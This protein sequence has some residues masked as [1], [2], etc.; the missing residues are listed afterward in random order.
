MRKIFQ[1]IIFLFSIFIISV[2]SCY[3][4]AVGPSLKLNQI[5]IESDIIFKAKIISSKKIKNK[6]FEKYIGFT[7]LETKMQIISV[8]NGKILG[9]TVIFQHYGDD[10]DT[11]NYQM[12]S[13]QYYN[14]KKG[15]EYIVFAKNTDKKGIFRQLWKNHKSKMDQGVFLSADN[16]P[17]KKDSTIKQIIWDELIKLLLSSD[18]KYIVYS[19]KQLDLMSTYATW[20]K[21]DDFNR[22]DVMQKIHKFVLNENKELAKTAIRAM[23]RG[24]PYL[25]D[26]FADGWLATIGEGKIHGY[27]KWPKERE[28][29]D[30]KKYWE[31]LVSVV[32]GNGPVENRALA[33]RALGLLNES[34]VYKHLIQWVNDAEPLIRQAAII[35]LSDFPGKKTIQLIEKH[36]RDNDPKTR[37][38]VARAIGFGRYEE[39]TPV[40]E[41]LLKDKDRY[42]ANAAYISL[43]SFSLNKVEHIFKTYKNDPDWKG[44]FVNALAEQNAEPYLKDLA[45]I[46]EKRISSKYFLGGRVPTYLSWKI[47]FKHLQIQ[48]AEKLKTSEFHRYFDALDNGKYHGSSEPRDL[49]A[50]YIHLG[51]IKRAKM[52]RK[53]CKER[54]RSNMEYF[55]KMVDEK[56]DYYI[57]NYIYSHYDIKLDEIKTKPK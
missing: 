34:K 52:F 35:L 16:K 23:G 46:I 6:W 25:S 9:E 36:S 40:L 7:A 18:P 4:Y 39:L 8:I 14:F 11:L 41:H 30:A 45:E 24:S 49:Y 44:L 2:S 48:S 57:D 28:N 53:K 38:G 15:R 26:D 37:L 22:S 43:L 51:M 12:F 3:A 17:I 32:N 55:F 33:I 1:L 54:I 29:K 42:V 20:D 13:P 50:F 5:V 31:D 27:S 10:K 19:I 47:L 56:K 21:L